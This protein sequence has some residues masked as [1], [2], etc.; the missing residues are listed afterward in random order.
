MTTIHLEYKLIWRKKV[1]FV[2]LAYLVARYWTLVAF[3]ISLWLMY[4]VS[5]SI[6]KVARQA[7]YLAESPPLCGQACVRS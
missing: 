4:I 5:L 7:A 6:T 1:S 3:S 2:T